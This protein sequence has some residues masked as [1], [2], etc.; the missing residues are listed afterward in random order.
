MD[1]TVQDQGRL[2][3]ERDVR[4]MVRLVADAA[5]ARGTLAERKSQLMAGLCEL[6]EGDAW[7][8]MISRDYR[9]GGTPVAVAFN[10]GGMTPQQ[11]ALILEAQQDPKAPPPENDTL[12]QLAAEHERFTFR[13][14]DQIADGDW[15]GHPGFA[16]RR[17]V[18]LDHFIFSVRRVGRGG[19]HSGVGVHRRLG[20]EPFDE[21]QRAIVDVVLS[22]VGWLHHA[23]LPGEDDAVPQLPPRHRAVL[24]LLLHGLARKEIAAQLHLSEHTVHGYTKQV[25]RHFGVRSRTELFARFMGGQTR[26]LPQP[27]LS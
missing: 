8:W 19:L 4:A 20:R 23:G 5:V 26:P 16:W 18:G 3:A 25:Y 13:R 27:Q 22:E 1:T 15:Y 2:L 17:R 9:P 7:V 6:V 12:I 24:G 11:L 21:R 10:Y 14:Q